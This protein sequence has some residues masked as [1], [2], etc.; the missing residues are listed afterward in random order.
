MIQDGCKAVVF[1]E[2]GKSPSGELYK[3]SEDDNGT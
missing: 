2:T 1:I 3:M